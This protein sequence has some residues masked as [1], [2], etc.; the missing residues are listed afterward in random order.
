MK[1]LSRKY[2][3]VAIT[4]IILLISSQVS[5]QSA[6]FPTDSAIWQC[7]H[8]YGLDP[9]YDAVYDYRYTGDTLISGVHYSKVISEGFSSGCFILG[10]E[11]ALRYDSVNNI[12]Y[13]VLPDSSSEEIMYNFNMHIGDTISGPF[14]Q[15][16]ISRVTDIDT[17]VY[18]GISRKRWRFSSQ[19]NLDP[20]IVEGIGNIDGL[21][22]P[23]DRIPI[24]D[25]YYLVCFS[26]KS[27]TLYPDSNGVCYIFDEI[28]NVERD[29]NLTIYPNPIHDEAL[30][31]LQNCLIQSVKLYNILGENIFIANVNTHEFRFNRSNLPNGIYYSIV[32]SE[33]RDFKNLILIN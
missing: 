30:F 13:I 21:F 27:F 7:S 18:A 16:A 29:F 25:N 3:Q 8:S 10:Y 26:Y 5:S 4:L 11:G 14:H 9:C 15:T 12:V 32:H 2:I 23:L 20:F 17:V 24:Q 19:M 33:N 1:N 6:K 31:V 22:T 28:K